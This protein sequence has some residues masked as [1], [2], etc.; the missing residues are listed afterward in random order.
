MVLRAVHFLPFSDSV[1]GI[2]IVSYRVYWQEASNS[3]S[4]EIPRFWTDASDAMCLVYVTMSKIVY[5]AAQFKPVA[6]GAEIHKIPRVDAATWVT[7][8]T[9]WS[10]SVESQDK[11]YFRLEVASSSCQMQLAEL[12]SSRGF[13]PRKATPGV[14]L[15]DTSPTSDLHMA[16]IRRKHPGD[17]QKEEI[18]PWNQHKT[19]SLKEMFNWTYSNPAE[20]ICKTIGHVIRILR[21]ND[22]ACEIGA[23][24]PNDLQFLLFHRSL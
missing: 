12:F 21:N 23:L 20:K 2:Q 15:I 18:R 10:F 5:A 16:T 3:C 14:V 1:F 13:P 19:P 11:V 8:L 17:V 24:K 4:L 9:T 7:L 6:E 22:E